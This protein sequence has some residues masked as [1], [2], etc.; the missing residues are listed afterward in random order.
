MTCGNRMSPSH[1]NKRGA[2]YRYYVSQ[3][4]LQRRPK[5]GRINQ[6]RMRHLRMRSSNLPDKSN[7]R[8]INQ[9]T[10]VQP[11]LDRVDSLERVVRAERRTCRGTAARSADAIG[12]V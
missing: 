6:Q 11:K 12:L 9:N 4:V 7:G 8:R 10:L 1:T 2:R 5:A 3:A